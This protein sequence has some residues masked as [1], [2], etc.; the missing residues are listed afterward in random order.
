MGKNG[1]ALF[2]AKSTGSAT[3]FIKMQE[4]AF[5][6][7]LGKNPNPFTTKLRWVSVALCGVVWRCV[8][9]LC[10]FLLCALSFSQGLRNV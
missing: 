2:S 1:E 7:N 4:G 6:K 8:A 3:K 5:K 10:Y 9:L